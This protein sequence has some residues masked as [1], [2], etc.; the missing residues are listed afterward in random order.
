MTGAG[1]PTIDSEAFERLLVYL[2][3]HR[4]F[5]FTGYKRS[6]LQRRISKR[7]QEVGVGDCDAYL[8]MLE[9][10]PEEFGQLFNSILINVSS[11]FRDPPVWGHVAGELI[12]ALLERKRAHDPIRAWSAGCAT[13]EEPY[14][15]AMLFAQALGEERFRDRVKVFAT[16]VDDDA[17][18]HARRATYTRAQLKDMPDGLLERYFEGSGD[19]LSVATDLRRSVIFGRNDLVRDAPISR[20]DLLACRNTLIYFNTE[21]QRS[22]MARLHMALADHGFMV[23]GK[24]ELILSY[25]DGFTPE[26]M[27]LRIFR[28]VPGVRLPAVPPPR[29][30]TPP[31]APEEK[32]AM[33]PEAFVDAFRVGPVAHLV[34]DREGTVV[35]ANRQLQSLFGVGEA[36]I[37]RS[38][39][40]LEISYR[41]VELRSL[42]EQATTAEEPVRSNPVTWRVDGEELRLEVRI[43]ALRPNGGTQTGTSI[44]FLDVTR[45]ARMAA[46]LETSKQELESAYEDLRSTV[47]E[48]ETTNE[49]L[50]STNEEL[51]TTN[52][53]LQSTNEELETMNEELQSSNEELETMNE[54][55]R[56]RTAELNSVNVLVDSMLGSLAMGVA[57]VDRELRVTMW[58]EQAKRLWGLDASDVRD[59]HFLNLEIGLPVQELRDALRECV[60]GGSDGGEQRMQARDRAGRDIVCRVVCTPLKTARGEVDGAIVLMQPVEALSAS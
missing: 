26:N 41:P 16:D 29:A 19:R 7:M 58:N 21:T 51:E 60:S 39:Q 11:F 23:L 31:P 5:D 12:P 53:E 59:Q 50:Q 2:R 25:S 1:Q 47:E 8:D 44:A 56:I 37:G 54:E 43:A 10:T 52:E 36:D 42:I 30:E 49:E 35:F 20:I 45:H 48:L 17:L 33:R 24:S 57:V 32:A 14:T 40:D 28:K 6:S 15:L 55:L 18:E 3:D 4:G 13:G 27:G 38:L 34:L 46:E 22:V 9:V